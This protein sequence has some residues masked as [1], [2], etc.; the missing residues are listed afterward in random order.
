MFILIHNT[1]DNY[2]NNFINVNI[3]L[4]IYYSFIISYSIGILNNYIILKN[5][6]L[7]LK[8]KFQKFKTDLYHG[9]SYYNLLK[10]CVLKIDYL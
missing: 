2:K 6:T 5:H 9:Y 10:L 7:Y 4:I 8:Y 3:I 1:I